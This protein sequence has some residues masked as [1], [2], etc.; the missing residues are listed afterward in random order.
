MLGAPDWA[1]D[2][3]MVTIRPQLPAS[4]SGTAAHRH[5]VR[6]TAHW[7]QKPLPSRPQVSKCSIG[8]TVESSD[9]HRSSERRLKNRGGSKTSM[10]L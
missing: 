2:D 1:L 5:A 9:C 7:Y 10:S 8:S 3:E 4:M 6:T